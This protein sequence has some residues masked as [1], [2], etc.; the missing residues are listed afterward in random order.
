M[1]TRKRSI[2]LVL[3]KGVALGGDRLYNKTY[4]Y[5]IMH[6]KSIR[7]VIKCFILAILV[8]IYIVHKLRV[9][10]VLHNSRD[11]NRHILLWVFFPGIASIH[12]LAWRPPVSC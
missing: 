8:A 5:L 3:S 4:M 1:K 6:Q 7:D 11:T 12:P 10:V 9:P 2:T